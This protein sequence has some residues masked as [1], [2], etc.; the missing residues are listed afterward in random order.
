M[1]ENE[2]PVGISILGILSLII[3]FFTAV[4][5]VRL[6][7]S[8]PFYLAWA[9]P[10]AGAALIG[11]GVAE[12]AFGGGCL[13]G[14]HWAWIL[15]VILLVLYALLFLFALLTEIAF[16]GLDFAY[17]EAEAVLVISLILFLLFY[18]TRPHVRSY[19][20]RT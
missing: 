6:V 2:R 1:A 15:G 13:R 8:S 12:M 10:V 4:S 20:G 5:G 7:L 19:F 14:W 18:L 16:A 3:G 11:I 9:G 17:P